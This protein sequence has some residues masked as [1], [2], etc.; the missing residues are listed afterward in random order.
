MLTNAHN[1]RHDET[2]VTF[3][4]GRQATG[5]VL[6]ADADLDIAVIDVDTGDIEPVDW[7]EEAGESVEI[8]RAVLAL[9]NPGGRGLR[10]TPGFVSS[11]RA[12][13]PWP[14]RPTDQ[15]CDRAHRAAAARLLG[16]PAGRH[17]PGGCSESTRSASMAG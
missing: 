13:L 3:A 5:K 14:P 6:G 11:T 15:R 8:G 16:R 17:V 4:D 12:Q 7:P 9:S 10:V 2:T 1:L